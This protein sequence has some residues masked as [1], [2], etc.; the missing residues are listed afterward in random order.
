MT[1]TYLRTHIDPIADRLELHQGEAEVVAGVRVMPAAGHTWG[2]QVVVWRDA[3]GTVCYPGD[4]MP[5][6]HHAH[7]SAS[8]GYDM[9][10]YQTMLTKRALLEL[11]DQES[12]RLVLDHQPGECVARRGRRF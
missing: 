2:H 10:P 6:I 3:E 1:R 12:W 9:L 11:A 8:L 7:L 4:V 5:T